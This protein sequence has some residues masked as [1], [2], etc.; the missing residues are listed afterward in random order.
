MNR[1]SEQI[2][3]WCFEIEMAM[4]GRGDW[5]TSHVLRLISK[6]DALNRGRLRAAFPDHVAAWDR[7]QASTG[8]FKDE[9]T[10]GDQR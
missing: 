3:D 9:R 5:F 7:W 10:T 8:E 4:S 6:A 1:S 2:R